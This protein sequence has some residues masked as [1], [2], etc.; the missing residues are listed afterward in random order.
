MHQSTQ[1]AEWVRTGRSMS[2]ATDGAY[3]PVRGAGAEPGGEC[4][5]KVRGG[6]KNISKIQAKYRQ[7]HRR[8]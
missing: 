1:A 4:P 6:K 7:R 8:I 5:Y 2:A 3:R